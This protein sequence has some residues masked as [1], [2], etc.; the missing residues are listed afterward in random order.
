MLGGRAHLAVET[1]QRHCAAPR[2]CALRQLGRRPGAL[3]AAR[4]GMIEQNPFEKTRMW[5]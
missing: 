2:L 3:A 1:Q 5:L 4:R